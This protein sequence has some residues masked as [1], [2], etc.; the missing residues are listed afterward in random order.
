MSWIYITEAG[1]RLTKKG[2]RYIISRENEVV[3]EVPAATVEGAAVIDHVEVSAAVL[4]DFLKRGI[5]FTWLSSKGEF[6]GRLEST[7]DQD[8]M[9]QKLQ[10]AMR[11]DEPFSFGLSRMIVFGKLYNQMTLLR[12]YNRTKEDEKIDMA[13]RN[14]RAAAD[15]LHQARTIED[16]MGY[17]GIAARFYFAALGAVVPE[18]FRFDKRT[19]QPPKDPF[20]SLLSFGYTL[21][22]Y[23]FY[24]AITQAGLHP[25]VGFLH[26]LRNGHPA[27]ASDLM[28]PWRPA[29]ADAVALALVSRKEIRPE[30]FQKS[31][32]NDGIYLDRVGRRIF[33]AAYEKKMQSP[34]KYFGGTYS[35]RH[36]LRM[37]VRSFSLALARKD[38]SLFKPLVIR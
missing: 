6:Y 9:R 29:V 8:V 18:A 10:F 35:W 11:D 30:H 31:E 28:E 22:M 5:P 19:R 25:Y 13:R 32:T 33:L 2:G 24:T 36:T 7:M 3:G 21:L 38:I 17:E 37:Q 26:A 1:A 27:L 16:I 15:R 14:I 23:D 12:R 4:V 20:N 34:S